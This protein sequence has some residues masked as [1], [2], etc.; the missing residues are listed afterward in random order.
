MPRFAC[1]PVL[2]HKGGVRC[3]MMAGA[4]VPR[5]GT[6]AGVPGPRRS[7]DECDA[8]WF[9]PVATRRRSM[10]GGLRPPHQRLAVSVRGE[11]PRSPPQATACLAAACEREPRSPPTNR[12]LRTRRREPNWDCVVPGV[13][14]GGGL[15]L[16]GPDGGTSVRWRRW[17]A[18]PI[19]G[20]SPLGGCERGAAGTRADR[21]RVVRP[22][23]R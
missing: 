17:L 18:A 12:P 10:I 14:R 7:A 16:G 6:D 1:N 9:A 19:W 8:G 23:S 21:L 13:C 22:R 5:R 20:H 2:T 11:T 3:N 4:L 15:R